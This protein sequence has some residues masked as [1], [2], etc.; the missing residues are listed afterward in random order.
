[1]STEVTPRRRMLPAWMMAAVTA[2]HGSPSFSPKGQSSCTHV[3]PF[4]SQ[5]PLLHVKIV[6]EIV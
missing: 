3:W 1:M 5:T 4:T 2:P 6:I